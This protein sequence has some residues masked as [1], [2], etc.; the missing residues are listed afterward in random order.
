MSNASMIP[1]VSIHDKH[2][3]FLHQIL[4]RNEYDHVMGDNVKCSSKGTRCGDLKVCLRCN[5]LLDAEAYDQG[6]RRS[7]LNIA[8]AISSRSGLQCLLWPIINR[9]WNLIR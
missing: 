8:S 1:A 3:N 4:F 7:A 6:M 2:E 9:M 5:V